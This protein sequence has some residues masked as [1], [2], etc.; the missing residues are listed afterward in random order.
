MKHLRFTANERR[1]IA[2]ALPPAAKRRR[3]DPLDIVLALSIAE[4]HGI[5]TMAAAELCGV[6]PSTVRMT[7]SRWRR[8]GVLPG[9]VAAA[10]DATDR[11]RQEHCRRLVPGADAVDW[12]ELLDQAIP[13]G[14]AGCAYRNR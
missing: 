7:C 5:S 3:L 6:N 2:L 14:L 10:R 11:L 4:A 9:I 12:L 1:H 13:G 8:D